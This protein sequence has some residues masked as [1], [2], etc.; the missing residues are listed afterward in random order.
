MRADVLMVRLGLVASRT[1]AREAI[2]A[3][4]VRLGKETLSK[5]SQLLPLDARLELSPDAG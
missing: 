3:G 5:A 2:A 4:Q 1:Q